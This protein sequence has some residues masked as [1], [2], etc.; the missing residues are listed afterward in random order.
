M[1]W[2]A[3]N[4]ERLIERDKDRQRLLAMSDAEAERLP[5]PDRYQRMRYQREIEAAEWLANL[6][7]SLP[8][9]P[10]P[11]AKQSKK[12]YPTRKT[13]FEYSQD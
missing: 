1:D 4:K 3:K 11:M 12:S 2:E 8:P 13:K 5:V 10:E 9:Q 6:R 7:R